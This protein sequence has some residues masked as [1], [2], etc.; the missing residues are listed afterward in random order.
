MKSRLSAFVLSHHARN[1]EQISLSGLQLNKLFSYLNFDLS[2]LSLLLL[3]CCFIF[4][5]KILCET[6]AM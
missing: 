6:H 1:G 4:T 2:I 5:F 3:F